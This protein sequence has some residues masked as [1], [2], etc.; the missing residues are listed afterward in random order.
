MDNAFMQVIG[1]LGHDVEL[2]YTDGGK[3]F[4]KTTVAVEVGY[5]EKKETEWMSIV[6]WGDVPAQRFHDFC[7]KGTGVFL[8]GTPKVNAWKSKDGEAKGQI[9]LNVR[10]FR[11]LKNG[12]PKGEESST[13]YDE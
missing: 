4:A 12:K 5:G 13:P 3:L 6:V 11:V 2:K 9:D 1:N 8:S 10:E 7:Q